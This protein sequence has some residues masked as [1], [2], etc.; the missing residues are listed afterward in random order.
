MTQAARALP[1]LALT[2][3]SIRLSDLFFNHTHDHL[4]VLNVER[5]G[6]DPATEDEQKKAL[7]QDAASFVSS[8][9]GWREDSKEALE[10]GELLAEDLLD[11]L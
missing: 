8:L 6:S 9:T 7:I 4:D 1:N 5:T 3:D 11:R 10:L 2:I